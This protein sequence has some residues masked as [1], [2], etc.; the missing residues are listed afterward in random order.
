MSI[1]DVFMPISIIGTLGASIFFFTRL[2][3][4]YNLRKKMIDKGYVNEESQSIFKKHI[5]GENRHVSLKWGLLFLCGGIALILM[6][7]LDVEPNS[8]LP[9]G[10]FAT[11]LSIGFLIYYVIVRKD[12]KS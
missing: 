8:P 10:L 5:N 1:F 2:I 11:S 4:E 3:T 9:Y 6:E 7:Y 12:L